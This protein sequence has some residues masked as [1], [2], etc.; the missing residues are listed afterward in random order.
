MTGPG[1]QAVALSRNKA[2]G[3]TESERQKENLPEQRRVRKWGGTSS[4]A[5]LELWSGCVTQPALLT[6]A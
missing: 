2:L 6:L 1:Q 3:E 4:L 5:P